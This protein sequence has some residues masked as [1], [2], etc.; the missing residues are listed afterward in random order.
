MTELNLGISFALLFRYVGESL[1]QLMR[2][3]GW[4]KLSIITQ[5]E[6]LF[7]AVRSLA[8]DSNVANYIHLCRWQTILII[9]LI[10]KN[11]Y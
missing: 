4:R 2:E 7:R 3:F 8:I 5:N 9:Y 1:G 6:S 10:M 11:G